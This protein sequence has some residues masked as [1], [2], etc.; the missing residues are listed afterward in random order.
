MLNPK[1]YPDNP[2]IST[3]TLK[4]FTQLSAFFPP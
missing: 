1:K 2:S 4:S 3:G